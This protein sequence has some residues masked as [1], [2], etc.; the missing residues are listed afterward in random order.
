MPLLFALLSACGLLLATCGSEHPFSP[1][2]APAPGAR[3]FKVMTFNIQ[4]GMNNGEYNLQRAVDVI[5]RV[6]PDLVGLQE[7][8]RNHPSYRCD[9]QPAL[10]A[11]RLRAATGR[12]WHHVY[13]QEWFVRTDLTCVQKG[14]GDAPNSEGLA[15]LAPEPFG[16][17]AHQPLFNGRL[18]LAVRLRAGGDVPVVVTHLASGRARGVEDR[19]K[20]IAQLLPWAQGQGAPQLLIGD[21]NATPDAPELAP[22]LRAYRDAW[23]AASR[24]GT[25]RGV[26]SGATRTSGSA[27]VDY[28]LYSPEEGGLR[29]EWVETVDT[30]ALIGV[31]ASDHHPV[32]ASFR[33]P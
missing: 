13:I 10:M 30:S 9:D 28:I 5:A 22:L 20:Q 27:R 29:L 32:V 3:S 18:G 11:E 17:V 4:H 21:L 2:Q 6:G 23:A 15:F 16:S 14:T 19:T 7:V 31:H 24:A 26:A 12:T 1:S 33:L 8:T 25:A